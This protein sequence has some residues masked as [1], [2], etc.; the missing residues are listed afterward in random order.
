[1]TDNNIFPLA[2]GDFMISLTSNARDYLSRYISNL[3]FNLL[4]GILTLSKL[5]KLSKLFKLIKFNPL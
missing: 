5:S 3:L 1:M 4:S 2:E